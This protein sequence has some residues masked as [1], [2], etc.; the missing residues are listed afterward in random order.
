[1]ENL[2]GLHVLLFGR[3]WSVFLLFFLFLKTFFETNCSFQVLN[4]V[5]FVSLSII[6]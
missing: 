4:D 3:I 1:M 2:I 6:L 5:S